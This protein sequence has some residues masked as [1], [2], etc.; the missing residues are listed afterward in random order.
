M[1][2]APAE[3]AEMA[4]QHLEIAE[5]YLAGGQTEIA[6]IGFR[7]VLEFEPGN[8]HA[9][10]RIRELDSS[11]KPSAPVPPPFAR[12]LPPPAPSWEEAHGVLATG[13]PLEAL[14]LF[15]EGWKQSHAPAAWDG[16]LKAMD[17]VLADRRIEFERSISVGSRLVGIAPGAPEVWSFVGE[18][19]A[20]NSMPARSL[21][22]RIGVSELLNEPAVARRTMVDDLSKRAARSAGRPNVIF[23]NVTN[24]GA[25]ALD[26]ILRRLLPEQLGYEPMA[27]PNSS[28]GIERFL[29]GATP[30]YHWTHSGPT[31][32]P[33]QAYDASTR[34]LCLHR[35]PRDVL[36]SHLRDPLNLQGWKDRPPQEVLRSLMCGAF[37]GYFALANE[38]MQLDA[39]RVMT[40]TFRELTADVPGTVLR[41]LKFLG[42]EIDP[43]VVQ[44]VCDEYSF[45]R[46]AGRPRGSDGPVVRDSYMVR[47]GTSGGWRQYFTPGLA[48]LFV[49]HCGRFL[50]DWGYEPDHRWASE[51]EPSQP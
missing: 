22:C 30:F 9:K 44:S 27:G 43:G 33:R 29:C 45:E 15:A 49:E 40:L 46:V 4:R 1:N 7:K 10:A 35:D 3:A 36:V 18:L 32:F 34:I 17:A 8:A 23:F 14:R 47:S 28:A 50:V 19:F 20:R 24:S 26:P 21:A 16:I 48:R 39:S 13:D 42:Q 31:S 11:D 6:E 12:P 38:W 37:P 2:S 41:I 25:S 5:R 51:L